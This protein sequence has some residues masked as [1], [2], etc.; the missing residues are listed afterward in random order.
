MLV[1]KCHPSGIYP[2]SLFKLAPTELKQQCH[3]SSV[4]AMGS[5]CAF[6]HGL[7]HI[8]WGGYGEEVMEGPKE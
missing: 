2:A 4:M 3:S 7:A 6:P 1:D 5:I 8:G